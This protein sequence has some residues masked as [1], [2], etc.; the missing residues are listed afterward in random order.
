MSSN[1]V[2]NHTRDKQIARSSNFV[3]TRIITDRIG[4]HSV[5]LLSIKITIIASIGAF[6]K[7]K[8]FK[9]VLPL[10]P[11]KKRAKACIVYFSKFFG[12]IFDN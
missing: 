3:I 12:R 10:S 5:L 2:C 6:T 9:S 1:S 4:L 8:M 7:L 11:K